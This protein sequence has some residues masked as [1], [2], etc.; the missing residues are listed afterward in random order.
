MSGTMQA[1][2]WAMELRDC[3]PLQRLAAIYFASSAGTSSENSMMMKADIENFAIWAGIDVESAEAAIGSLED[4]DGVQVYRLDPEHFEVTLTFGAEVP[5]RREPDVSERFMAKPFWLY[6]IAT[7]AAVKVGI[8]GDPEQRFRGL[9]TSIPDEFKVKLLAQG[10]R[11]DIMRAEAACHA[12]LRGFRITGEWFRCSS[13]Q[14]VTTAREILSS[15]GIE[16]Q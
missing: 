3:E 16:P 2:T 8:T 14:A 10:K 12:N 11:R 5:P 1:M 15:Y 9:R 6:V 13:V 4:Y 7:E